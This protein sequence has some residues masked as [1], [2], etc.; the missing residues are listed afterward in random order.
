MSS[1]K[2]EPANKPKTTQMLAQKSA[3]KSKQKH[4]KLKLLKWGRIK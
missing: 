4:R 1:G 2:T 3:T